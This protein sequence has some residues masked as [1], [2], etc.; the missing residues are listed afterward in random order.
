M[1]L[2]TIACILVPAVARAD[3]AAAKSF[4]ESGSVAFALGDY[5]EAAGDYERAFSEKPD[6]ALLYN[7]AQAHRLAGNTRRALL[8][9]RSY[10]ATP[11][12]TDR[13][14]SKQVARRI[15]ELEDA[16]AGEEVAVHAEPTGTT[17]WTG[18]NAH[19]PPPVVDDIR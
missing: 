14:A 5:A 2:V 10:L 19:P 15:G 4:F 12:F 17:A 3:T 1:R 16:L 18:D 9:Y 6:P 7:A 8:L 11:L 13:P